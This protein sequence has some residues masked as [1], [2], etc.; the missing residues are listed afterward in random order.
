M[1]CLA[2]RVSPRRASYFLDG[3]KVTKEAT[4]GANTPPRNGL[5][6]VA[7]ISLVDFSYSSVRGAR[8][9]GISPAARLDATSLSQQASL[10]VLPRD[11]VLIPIFRCW[12]RRFKPSSCKLW[13]SPP[14]IHNCYL[15]DFPVVISSNELPCSFTPIRSRASQLEAGNPDRGESW[16]TSVWH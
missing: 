7:N 2:C 12:L 8:N 16:M 15:H 1:L 9:M 3:K 13:C 10:G 6:S 5:V 14:A 11:L 4:S